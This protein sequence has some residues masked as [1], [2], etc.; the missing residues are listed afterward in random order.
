MA[1]VPGEYNAAT[2]TYDSLLTKTLYD[3]NKGDIRKH[4][5]ALQK[6]L[7]PQDNVIV[8]FSGHGTSNQNGFHFIPAD[9][10]A[11]DDESWISIKKMANDLAVQKTPDGQFKSVCKNLLFILDCCY[12]GASLSGLSSTT[13]QDDISRYVIASALVDEKASDGRPGRGSPFCA[14]ICKLLD[15]NLENEYVID[16]SQLV[17]EFAHQME[18]QFIKTPQKVV[19]GLLPMDH[20]NGYSKF[21]FELREKD[22]PPVHVI[23]N[24]F[25]QKLNFDKERT[26]FGDEMLVKDSKIAFVSL[27]EDKQHL[28]LMRKVIQDAIHLFFEEY[29]VSIGMIPTITDSKLTDNGIWGELRSHKANVSGGERVGEED[30]TEDEK[31]EI[32]KWLFE[33]ASSD[34]VSPGFQIMHIALESNNKL[35]VPLVVEFC[36]ELAALYEKTKADSGQNNKLLIILTEIKKETDRLISDF[37]TTASLN[38]EIAFVEAVQA[39]KVG[40][41]AAIKWLKETQVRL[42]MQR[43]KNMTKQDVEAA[44]FKKEEDKRNG[45]SVCAFIDAFCLYLFN[46]EALYKSKSPEIIR[47]LYED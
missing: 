47:Y 6:V 14:A 27:H 29:K 34:L 3:A 18:R 39:D 13:G 26:T 45:I 44:V 10:T 43:I 40:Q 23:C 11:D 38:D 33:Q 17:K 19:S 32:L 9:G 46:N 5:M 21:V 16:E 25:V 15:D 22:I 12:S 37:R 24:T 8:Y 36:K 35:V 4:V 28:A 2:N 41:V 7:T 30:I 31:L 20:G 1:A 42:N